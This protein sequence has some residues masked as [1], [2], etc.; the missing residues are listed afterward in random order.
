MVFCVLVMD[1]NGIPQE[2]PMS[3]LNVL[4]NRNLGKC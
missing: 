1:C 4:L 3:L 2:A